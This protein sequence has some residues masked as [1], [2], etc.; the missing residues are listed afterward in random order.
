MVIRFAD[1]LQGNVE[2]GGG[3][4]DLSKGFVTSARTE[5]PSSCHDT[6][7]ADLKPLFSGL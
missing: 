4:G 5:D 1:D 3:P 7:P 2:A 6:T